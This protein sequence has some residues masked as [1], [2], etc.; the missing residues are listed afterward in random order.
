MCLAVP[1]R[2]LDIEAGD[3][4]FRT[5]RVSFGGI[6]K[7]VSLACVPE[8]APDD[9]VLV[10][11]GMALA[12]VDP[13]ESEE[14]LAYLRQ[15]GEL[16]E[17]ERERGTSAPPGNP[18]TGSPGMSP[19]SE[20]EPLMDAGNHKLVPSQRFTSGVSGSESRA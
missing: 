11:A 19:N 14:S 16:E 7:R 12:V 18:E 9:F 5:G 10:H 20:A 8:A 4:H 13:A 2:I 6:V 17:L 15:L 1:G 3:P